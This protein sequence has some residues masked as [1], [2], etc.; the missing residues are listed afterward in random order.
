M[1]LQHCRKRQAVL[2]ERART[3]DKPVST[4]RKILRNILQCYPFKI[5]HVQEL[6]PADLP[7]REAFALQ[8]LA[9]M[10]VDNAWPW[11]ILWTDEARFHLKVLSILKIA[12]FGQ[13]RISFSNATIASSFSKGHC[14]V[15]FTATFIVGPF[16][17]GDW[18]FGY[19]NL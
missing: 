8:F 12:E 3:L 13:E 4:F 1:W 11:K 5:T 2:W 10:K 16:F 17:R 14:V 18:S 7:K 15:G 6:V 19:C 9:R